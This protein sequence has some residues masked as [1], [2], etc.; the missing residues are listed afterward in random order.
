M[1]YAQL[2][3]RNGVLCTQTESMSIG[4]LSRNGRCLSVTVTATTSSVA[5]AAAT[6]VAKGIG[7]FSVLSRTHLSDPTLETLVPNSLAVHCGVPSP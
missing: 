7:Q 1:S 4:L 6:V 3:E 2:T 5:T